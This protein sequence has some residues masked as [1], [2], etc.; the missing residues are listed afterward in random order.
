M[1]INRLVAEHVHG[2][3]PIDITFNDDLTFITGLNGCGKTTALR[4]L[5]ALLTPNLEEFSAIDFSRAEVS[6]QERD[7]EVSIY[8][9][10]FEEGL[11][12]AISTIPIELRISSAEL[13][14]FSESKTT[15]DGS[16]SPVHEKIAGHDVIQ[17]ILKLSTPMFLGLDRRFYIQSS[18]WEDNYDARRRDF[19]ARRFFA[20]DRGFRGAAAAGLLDVSYL[21]S[22]RMQEILTLQESLDETFRKTLLTRV[23]EYKP[24]DMAD[25][26]RLP[27]RAELE[28]YR[29]RLSRI[30]SAAEALKVPLPEIKAALSNFFEGMSKVVDVLENKSKQTRSRTK[31]ARKETQ[32]TDKDKDIDKIHVEWIINKPQADRILEHL[33]LL[34]TFGDN[35]D[36]LREPIDKFV[37][38]INS[39]LE[40]TG[41]RLVVVPSGELAISLLGEGQSNTL[42]SITALSSGE[43]QLLVMLAHLSLNR[44]LDKS[45]IFIVDEPELSLHLDWQEKFVDAIQ[46]ANPSVQLIMATHSPAII[47]DRTENC[48]SMSL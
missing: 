31:G 19:H 2:T 44:S 27:S 12:L 30:E 23:F 42:R 15:T 24:S 3:F 38:L 6:L 39:F 36:Q 34:S 5:M 41:K 1:R 29:E 46:E 11:I 8:A 18:P 7:Q 10:R 13:Q 16:K 14:L 17:A 37:K 4:L 47:L 20:E 28:S 43:R 25:F 33:Q 32:S 35:R 9:R 45:G 26:G 40:Q 22:S 21:A 48:V